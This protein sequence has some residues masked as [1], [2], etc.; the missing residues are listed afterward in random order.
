MDENGGLAPVSSTPKSDG[1]RLGQ[2]RFTHLYGPRRP[3]GLDCLD[4]DTPV[5]N[6]FWTTRRKLAE[7]HVR[8]I[9]ATTDV[10]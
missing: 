5:I 6:R 2:Q 4:S 1:N 3:F 10:H 7:T 9:T 8:H